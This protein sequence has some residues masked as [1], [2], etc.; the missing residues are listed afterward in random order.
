MQRIRCLR[1]TLEISEECANELRALEH[2]YQ[3]NPPQFIFN[4][5]A[6]HIDSFWRQDVV[7][8]L[9]K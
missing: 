6:E 3:G 5:A 9:I 1:N 8:I 2:D 4:A 7:D